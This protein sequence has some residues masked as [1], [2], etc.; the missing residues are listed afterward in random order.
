[1][2]Q[3]VL[4]SAKKSNNF[5]YNFYYKVKSNFK[6]MMVI[7][8]LHLVAAPLNII[9]AMVYLTQSD[10]YKLAA[11]AGEAGLI[12]PQFN[13]LYPIIG[14]IATLIAALAGILIALENFNYLHKKANVDM[15]LSLPLTTDQRFFSD[16]LAGIFTYLVPFIVSTA[17]TM[18]VNGIASITIAGWNSSF[19]VMTD[20]STTMLLLHLSI[21]GFFIM[22]MAFALTVLV[23][24]CCGTFFES[25]FYTVLVNGLIPGTIAATGYLLLGSLYGIEPNTNTLPFIEMTSPIGGVIGLIRSLGLDTGAIESHFFSWLIPFILVTFLF[26]AATFFLYKHRKAEQVSKPF[27][28]K[29]FYYIII[30]AITFC[31]GIIFDQMS[32]ETLIPFIITTAIVYL[33]FEVITNRGFKKFWLSGIRYVVTIAV[34][35]GFSAIVNGSDGFGTVYKLPK[36]ESVMAVD[37]TY[38]GVFSDT[39][40]SSDVRHYEDAETIAAVLSAHKTNLDNHRGN[41]KFASNSAE[42]SLF[43]SSLS[44][45]SFTAEQAIYNITLRYKL[46]NGRVLERIYDFSFE[47]YNMLMGIDLTDEYIDALTGDTQARFQKYLRQSNDFDISMSGLYDN[48]ATSFLNK[49]NSKEQIDGFFAALNADMK[50]IAKTPSEYYAPSKQCLGI[51]EGISLR[52]PLNENYVNTLKFFKDNNISLPKTDYVGLDLQDAALMLYE[53]RSKGTDISGEEYFLSTGNTGNTMRAGAFF[54]EGSED[55]RELLLLAQPYYY[56][57]EACYSVTHGPRQYII[58]PQYTEL[59]KKLYDGGTIVDPNEGHDG[60]SGNINIADGSSY[61]FMD[62]AERDEILDTLVG[63]NY[64]ISYDTD[65]GVPAEVGVPADNS[66]VA[67]IG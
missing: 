12:R 52:V 21:G 3:K 23:V 29:V 4:T 59:A 1:M 8:V 63:E 2:T 37:M 24:N 18:G 56:T 55:L 44:S 16:Y 13:P 38:N 49:G 33:L 48:S 15:V 67:I 34:I 26:F 36:I 65:T 66:S 28:Y 10:A 40:G 6:I 57:T 7:L 14:I 22:L 17:I 50:E 42:I 35:L 51:I 45:A 43:E 9:N 64:I 11:S 58:P 25:S 19:N 54:S 60:M 31:F 5:G 30:T 61:Y 41:A 27:V 46:K 47:E 20:T 32:G 53:P 39:Y 62:S